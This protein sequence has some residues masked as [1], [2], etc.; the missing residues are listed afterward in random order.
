MAKKLISLAVV[1]L[2]F[3]AVLSVTVSAKVDLPDISSDKTLLCYTLNSSGKAYAYSDS[4]LKKKNGDS[5]SPKD[6]VRIVAIKDKAVKAKYEVDGK[7]KTAWFSTEVFTNRDLY[8]D[9][10]KMKF[11]SLTEATVYK[12]K[13][14]SAVL[15]TLPADYVCFLVRGDS[16]SDWVQ[17]IYYASG[18]YRMG[19]VTASAY[20]EI[21]PVVTKVSLDKTSLTLNGKSATVKLQATVT[22]E[23][24]IDKKI[25]WS[26]TD[27]SVVKVSS[28]GR[29]TAV[30]NGT[31]KIVAKTANGTKAVCKVTVKNVK[32]SKITISEKTVDLSIGK[33]YNLSATSKPANNTDELS[34][35]TSSSSVAQVSSDGKITATGTG[36][37]VITAQTSSGK[38]AKVNVTVSHPVQVKLDVPSYK[39]FDS[40][41]A[42]VRI[43]SGGGPLKRGGCITTC[44]AMLYSYK[45]NTECTPD[46]MISKLSY[47]NGDLIWSCLENIG[48]TY[49][50]NY[51]TFSNSVMKTIYEKLREG[52]PV[53]LGFAPTGSKNQ[54]WVVVT[55]Y[56]GNSKTDFKASDFTINDA[57]SS[58]NYKLSDITSQ[59]NKIKGFVW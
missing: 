44:L 37:A 28:S 56:V 17:I 46:K 47:S 43:G 39:Q 36:T 26:S 12:R 3:L 35:K 24:A 8:K 10:A 7:T 23:T 29:V 54:H 18:T 33:T 55:G 21:L 22:P 41:W 15:G 53:M 31:A 25:K 30:N 1:I 27:T 42:T 20:D 13:S 50:E 32:A 59:R 51:C 6:E 2:S 57:G 49:T 52:K 16:E 4:A 38:T 9:G 58:Y 11:R 19:W 14:K 5:I 48:L 34:W 40:R 45:N